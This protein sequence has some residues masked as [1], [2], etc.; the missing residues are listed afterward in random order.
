RTLDQPKPD[1]PLELACAGPASLSKMLGT[2]PGNEKPS[3]AERSRFAGL[4]AAHG[5]GEDLWKAVER[6]DLRAKLP[7]LKRTLALQQLTGS[8]APMMEALQAAPGAGGTESTAYLVAVSPKEWRDLVATHGA[9]Q[10]VPL[11]LYAERLQTAVE[12]E[13]PAAALLERLNKNEVR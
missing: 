8:H 2:I 7:A 5:S 6:S 4:L 11:A 13:Y 12:R 3:E 9:P 1:A 10:G